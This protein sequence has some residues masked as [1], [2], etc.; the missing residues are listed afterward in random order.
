MNKLNIASTGYPGTT[1]SWKFIKDS[2]EM[3][4]NALG[5]IIETNDAVILTGMEIDINNRISDGYLIYQGEIFTFNGGIHTGTIVLVEEVTD[6]EYNTDPSNSGQLQSLPTYYKRYAKP[7]N[8]GEGFQDIPFSDFIRL[9]A[10]ITISERTKQATELKMGIAKIATQ[11]Q[12][13]SDSDDACI[14]TPKK[15][16]GRTANE[17]RNGLAKIATQIETIEGVDDSKIVTP[18][19]LQYKLDNM[20][21]KIFKKFKIDNISCDAGSRN[22]GYQLFNL[23]INIGKENYMIIGSFNGDQ[24]VGVEL[25]F[26]LTMK[27]NDQEFIANWT[28]DATNIS[29]GGTISGYIDL[30]VVRF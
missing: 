7:G 1:E 5:K 19:K 6:V 15:L 10:L 28:L 24:T 23:G 21:L 12:A 11:M 20:P 13:N 9:D 29:G 8:P 25:L 18:A 4:A 27:K 14:I 30:I 26:S 2:Y 3:I 16:S 17:N 22:S